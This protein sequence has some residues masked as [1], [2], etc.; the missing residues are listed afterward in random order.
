MPT[1]LPTLFFRRS[2]R[3]NV[4]LSKSLA[5]VMFCPHDRVA[6]LAEQ[7]TFNP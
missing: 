4:R 3:K 1:K 6:Q 2:D 7:R 5:L